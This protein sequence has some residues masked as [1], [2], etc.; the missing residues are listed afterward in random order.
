VGKHQIEELKRIKII[1]K[2]LKQRCN[3]DHIDGRKESVFLLVCDYQ[4]RNP[5]L[6]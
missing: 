5:T 2:K 6:P 1:E 3:D 4:G